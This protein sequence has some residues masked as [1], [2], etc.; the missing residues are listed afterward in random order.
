M[1]KKLTVAV[2]GATG[3]V[4][5]EMLK[6]LH[7]RDFPATEVRAFA[8][9]RSAGTTVPFGE[10]ELTVQELK[11]DVFEGIDLAIFSA[12][13]A[14]SLTF[15]PHAAHAG[16]VV[17]DNSSTWR[18]DDRCPLV[19]PEVNAQALESHNGIIANPN[20][21][22]IQMMVALKPLHDAAKIKRVVVSTYQAVSGTGQK[23][24]EE[25]ER[26]V[27][28]LFNGRDPENKTYPYRIAFNCLPHIDVFL[29]NDYTKEEMKMVH[30]TVKIFNDP[31]VK[32]TATCVRVP[33]FYC[34]AESVNVETEKKISAKDARVMLAQA[35]GVRVFDNP[36][37]LMYPMPGYCVGDDHTYVGRIRE[38]ETIENGLNMWIV[39][40]NVRKGAALNTVQIA[41]ELVQRGLVR[42]ADKNVFMS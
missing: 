29:E 5:R 20:C 40:D 41:E 26:Q 4:G 13:G 9:A 10:Q 17:V 16:C 21:S 18:M 14:A 23:G 31:S 32:V 42:V 27:R 6:T 37:E 38:D 25:L 22:T 39:A 8:S 33:V 35:P 24:I 11:E 1:S 15:A 30:E 34:H 12:G 36:R 3:A 28:D 19:V 2:V 7:E